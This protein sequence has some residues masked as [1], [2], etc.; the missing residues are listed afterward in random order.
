MNAIDK[1]TIHYA[2]K[3]F[4]NEIKIDKDWSSQTNQIIE[5]IAGQIGHI[6]FHSEAEATGT[7]LRIFFAI[8]GDIYEKNYN[9]KIIDIEAET[10]KLINENNMIDQAQM[11]AGG[12]IK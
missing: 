11:I 8:C 1:T 6:N 12:K 4:L 7:A 2:A 3:G 10:I 5:T 9:N